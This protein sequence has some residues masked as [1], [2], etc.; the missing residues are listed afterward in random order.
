MF[1]EICLYHN[2]HDVQAQYVRQRFSAFYN[3][4]HNLVEKFSRCTIEGQ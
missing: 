3:R 4:Y 1:H 2:T